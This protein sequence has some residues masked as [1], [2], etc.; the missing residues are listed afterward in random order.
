MRPVRSHEIAAEP[1]GQLAESLLA[2]AES[3]RAVAEREA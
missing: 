2:V 1:F 3:D